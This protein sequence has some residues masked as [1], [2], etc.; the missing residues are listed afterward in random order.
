M[1][2]SLIHLFQLL[3][4]SLPLSSLFSLSLLSLSPR[5]SLSISWKVI[6][7]S[8]EPACN[9]LVINGGTG[10]IYLHCRSDMACNSVELEAHA[11]YCCA[12]ESACN[13]IQGKEM[14]R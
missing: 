6:C 12:E 10:D 4:C 7:E 13:S 3:H 2:G 9:S 5:P 14:L 1:I 8:A 11:E